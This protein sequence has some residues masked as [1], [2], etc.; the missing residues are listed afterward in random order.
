MPWP[1]PMPVVEVL[2]VDSHAYGGWKSPEEWTEDL[3]EAMWCRSIGWLYA[4]TRQQLVLM[5]SQGTAGKLSDAIV[6]PRCAVR[7]V[8]V[9]E[10]GQSCK[11]KSDAHQSK[12]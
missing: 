7:Q 4:R 9:L 12:P 1:K 5:Q 6:I 11:V 2:W 10:R 8:R 3:A